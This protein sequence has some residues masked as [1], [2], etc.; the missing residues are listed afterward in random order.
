MPFCPTCR[1]EYR[2]GRTQCPDC[3][4]PLVDVLDDEPSNV[5]MMD[6]Y[7]CFDEQEMLRSR[8]LLEANGIE[9]LVR[10]RASSAFPTTVGLT[11]TKILAVAPAHHERAR[12]IL[13]TAVAD[14]VLGSDGEIIGSTR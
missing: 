11:A 2:E 5:E 12:T 9:V 6:V 7:A 13:G 4:V 8:E 14:G 3:G 1:A 10:D